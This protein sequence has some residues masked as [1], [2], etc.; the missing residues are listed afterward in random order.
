MKN[1][2]MTITVIAEKIG[3]TPKT[4]VRWERTAKVNPAKRNWR[5]WRVYDRDDLKRLRDFKE[6]ITGFQEQEA[7]I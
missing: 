7:V 1:D 5:G 4:I 6:T 2:W 3:V